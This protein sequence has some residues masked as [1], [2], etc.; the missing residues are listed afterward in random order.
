M[1]AADIRTEEVTYSSSDTELK[2]YIA[3]DASVEGPRPGILVVHEWWGRNDYPCRRA[4]ELA[5]LGYTAM[6]LDMYGHGK[7]ADNPDEA[8]AL[9][10]AVVEDMETGRARFQAALDVIRNHSTVDATRIGA[11]G[12]CFGG[13]V[14][15]H[16]ARVGMDLGVVAS[17]HGSLPLAITP[18]VEKMETRVAVYNGEA[19]P[20]VSA[21]AIEAFKTEM[22]QAGAHCD[23]VQLPGALHAFTNPVATA[24]GEKYGIPL[25]YDEAADQVS[26]GHMQMVLKEVFGL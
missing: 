5:A 12:Y 9:M 14:V 19:D 6:A 23:F 4:R 1:S 3:W 7:L 25:R 8:G 16:M 17:F 11:I 18:G 2:G 24:N 10:N 13:G 15:L 26:W 20:F 21:E 22:E